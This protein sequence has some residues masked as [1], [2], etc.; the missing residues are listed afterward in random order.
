MNYDVK[1]GLLGKTNGRNAVLFEFGFEYL[2]LYWSYRR[3]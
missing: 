1:F 3:G 2:I